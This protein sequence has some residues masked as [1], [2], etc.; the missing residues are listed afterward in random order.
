MADQIRVLHLDPG[1]FG[2]TDRE[3]AV[4]ERTFDEVT[5]E[6]IRDVDDVAHY[7]GTADIV[8]TGG[9]P[10]TGEVLD[11]TNCGVVAVY[12]TGV[13]MVDLAAA[14]DRNVVVTRVPEYC[15]REVGEHTITLALALLRGVPQYEAETRDGGWDWTVVDGLQT[16]DGLVFGFLAFGRKAQTAADLASSLGFD[17]LAHDP[18]VE[19]AAVRESG[20]SPVSFEDLLERADVLSVHAPLTQETGGMLDASAFDRMKDG[21][22]LVNTSRGAVIDEG[23]LV[24]ALENG[25]PFGAGLD[26]LARE[27]PEPDHPLLTRDDVIVTPHAAWNSVGAAKRVRDRGSEIAFSAYEGR[28][29]E[30]V[31]NPEVLETN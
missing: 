26:V 19:D 22:I 12:A 5:I 23:A 28:N 11:A 9:T 6:S 3:A 29:V 20:A 7:A 13:D 17:V 1:I 21:A 8:A 2:D 27:P 4:F 31:V 30:G 25:T 18:Y 16:W 15:N 24:D 14:T 10:V